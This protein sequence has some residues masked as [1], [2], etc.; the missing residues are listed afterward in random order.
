MFSSGLY[1]IPLVHLD[2]LFVLGSR[3]NFFCIVWNR[4]S[5]HQRKL[6]PSYRLGVWFLTVNSFF[7]GHVVSE[8][9]VEMDQRKVA[10]I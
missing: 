1:E 9:G 4:S 3:S 5:R 7:L 6:V 10:T 2:N 8:K